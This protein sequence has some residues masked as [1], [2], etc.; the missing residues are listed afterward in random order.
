MMVSWLVRTLLP[1]VPRIKFWE[2]FDSVTVPPPF[3]VTLELPMTS[4]VALPPEFKDNLPALLMLV[5]AIVSAWL[6]LIPRQ[7]SEFMVRSLMVAL[8]S[9]LT[10]EWIALPQ[11]GLR[12]P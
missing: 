1:N 6:L 12:L 5:L 4:S 11:V 8:M 7:S 10:S 2:L 9:R 3:R